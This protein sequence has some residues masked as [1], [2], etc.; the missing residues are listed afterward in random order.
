[1]GWVEPSTK[2]ARFVKVILNSF[3]AK[4]INY[5]TQHV[6]FTNSIPGR[7]GDCVAA[8]DAV[9]DKSLMLDT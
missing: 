5:Q 8:V 1:M 9:D 7:G 4:R 2:V 6:K 3:N